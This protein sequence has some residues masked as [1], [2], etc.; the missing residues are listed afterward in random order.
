[1]VVV[2]D[3]GVVVVVVEVVDSVVVVDVVVVVEVV[4]V[5]DVVVVVVVTSLLKTCASAEAALLTQVFSLDTAVLCWSLV[6]EATFVTLLIWSACCRSVWYDR[7]ISSVDATLNWSLTLVKSSL[8]PCSV[9][10]MYGS[11]AR[12]DIDT[13]LTT[14]VLPLTFKSNDA[15]RYVPPLKYWD[16]SWPLADLIRL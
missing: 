9:H 4:V 16:T 1:M 15:G 10:S 11:N 14:R 5:V 13:P 7:V 8:N 2:V 3:S 12:P 6:R